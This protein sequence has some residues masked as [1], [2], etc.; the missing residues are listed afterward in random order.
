MRRNIL[1]LVSLLSA[2]SFLSACGGGDDDGPS[3]YDGECVYISTQHRFH[4]PG[5]C[6]LQGEAR[7]CESAE[8]E[9]RSAVDETIVACVYEGCSAEFDCDAFRSL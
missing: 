2:V 3:T 4:D 9:D 7:A 1:A 5:Q 8:L 6:A